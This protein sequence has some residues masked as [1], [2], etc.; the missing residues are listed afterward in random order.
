MSRKWITGELYV[1]T[2]LLKL[3]LG[4]YVKQCNLDSIDSGYYR[5]TSCHECRRELSGVITPK[6]SLDYNPSTQ[7]FL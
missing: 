4:R 6:H 1:W 5:M 2:R 3:V 7:D